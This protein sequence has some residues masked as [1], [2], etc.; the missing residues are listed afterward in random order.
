MWNRIKNYGLEKIAGDLYRNIITPLFAER[1][2]R[3]L[4]YVIFVF[5]GTVG[6][7]LI[8][9]YCIVKFEI[10]SNHLISIF[11]S[12]VQ[13]LATLAIAFVA[14][15]IFDKGDDWKLIA[16]FLIY[17]FLITIIIFIIMIF[18]DWIINQNLSLSVLFFAITTTFYA[19]YLTIKIAQ[20]RADN[21]L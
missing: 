2:R 20:K 17:T 10:A 4:F 12:M 14:L 3:Q 9:Y 6:F 19:F 8:Q 5:F 18:S 13:I 21:N 16:D 1:Y 7:G 15:E 11:G